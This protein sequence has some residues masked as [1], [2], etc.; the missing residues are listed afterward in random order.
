[1]VPIVRHH[2]CQTTAPIYRCPSRNVRPARRIWRRRSRL[3]RAR[4]VPDHRRR[5]RPSLQ[6]PPT[7]CSRSNQLSARRCRI[8]CRGTGLSGSI[9]RLRPRSRPRQSVG[10]TERRS[11]LRAPPPRRPTCGSHPGPT[12][13]RISSNRPG[14][15]TRSLWRRRTRPPQWRGLPAARQRLLPQC[16][17]RPTGCLRSNRLYLR[18]PLN[19][20]IAHPATRLS[21]RLLSHSRSPAPPVPR[22][23][24]RRLP[25]C[26]SRQE[27]P[28]SRSW[29]SRLPRR[30]SPK[31]KQGV[32]R[33]RSCYPL[34]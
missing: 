32:A 12:S 33:V 27:K 29:I 24:H 21:R 9:P 11:R 1:M 8:P 34:P 4:A 6:L 2:P 7:F 30:R 22:A 10:H 13:A 20:L 14:R 18:I 23:R 3:K 25:R 15:R 19:L 26:G 17:H 5:H 16:P 28:R 31:P